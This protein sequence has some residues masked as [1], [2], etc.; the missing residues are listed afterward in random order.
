MLNLMRWM[1]RLLTRYWR[2]SDRWM[3]GPLI[4]IIIWPFYLM[5]VA[6]NHESGVSAIVAML[7]LVP[8]AILFLISPTLTG[9]AWTVD[10]GEEI[11]R[12]LCTIVAT[13]LLIGLYFV[14]VPV[15]NKLEL[16]P[17]FMLVTITLV[18]YLAAGVKKAWAKLVTTG[19]GIML[20]GITAT[21]YLAPYLGE[22]RAKNPV[23]WWGFLAIAVLIGYAIWR[24]LKYREGMKF[25][26]LAALLVLVFAG[27]Q[28]LYTKAE[29]ELPPI[30]SVA[31]AKK[32]P[33]KADSLSITATSE[34][35][36]E[37]VQPLRRHVQIL[38]QD[39]CAYEV[40]ASDGTITTVPVAG[41]DTVRIQGPLNRLRV[42][43]KSPCPL[44]IVT[45]P[46]Q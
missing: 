18:L 10:E 14:V 19:L 3:R 27:W 29:V 4:W 25:A 24:S 44:I 8:L 21:F 35:S 39:A 23:P 36:S 31:E 9:L 41:S 37:I 6:M 12:V 33:P 15:E 5:F 16:V 38:P 28:M 1:R 40:K 45:T 26:A 46:W 13:E 30:V 32:L 7:P 20:V 2:I 22:L 43:A 42:K 11:L 34:W 17:V